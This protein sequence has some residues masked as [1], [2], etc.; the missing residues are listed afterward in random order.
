MKSEA[1][2]VVV[3]GAG[4]A[5]LYMVHQLKQ[6]G[7]SHRAF[8]RGSD[9]GGAWLANRYPGLVCDSERGIYSYSFSREL[10]EQWT[11]SN[12]YPSQEEILAYLQYVAFRFDLKASYDFNTSVV[13]ARFDEQRNTWLVETDRGGRVEARYLIAATGCLSAPQAP[14]L[15][16]LDRFQGRCIHTA[17]WPE[18]GVEFKGLHVGIV[19]TGSSGVQCIP[20]IAR[21]A[22]RLTVFQRTPHF[23]IPAGNGPLGTEEIEALKDNAEE[24]HRK[25]RWSQLGHIFE[26]SPLSALEAGVKQR[27]EQY[28]KDWREGGLRIVYGSYHDLLVNRDA[29]DTVAEFV[30][31]KIRQLVTN[32][33]VANALVPRGYPIGAKRLVLG[34]D[35]YETFNRDNVELVDLR[36]EPIEDIYADSIQTAD[37]TIP[38]DVIVLATGFDALT[39]PL[40]RIDIRGRGGRS[41]AEAWAPGWT[42]YLG[43]AVSGFPNLFTITGP[44]SPSVLSN[45]PTSIEQHV[46]WIAACLSAMRDRGASTIEAT[47]DA[48][49]AWVEHVAA[50]GSATLFPE[51]ESWY[52]GAN[53]SGKARKLMVYVGGVGPYWQR[54]LEVADRGYEGFSIQ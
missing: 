47:K 36:K 7:I 12:R 5:G 34:T 38:L 50:V 54:C 40:T 20:L 18:G 17:E 39:G 3:V 6:L 23:V 49:D 24:M 30:R 22:R 45:M 25:C 48:E 41:L 52:V 1:V 9:V 21:Q 26:F 4:F 2:D 16:G 13:R 11:W 53:I 35:Y 15:P 42:S 10:I 28:E 46:E 43:L 51:A 29:N 44:G 27:R 8:E 37:R 31:D 14:Q 32:P 19:G 33:N